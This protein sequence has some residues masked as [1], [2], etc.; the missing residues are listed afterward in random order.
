MY[1]AAVELFDAIPTGWV[2]KHFSVGLILLQRCRSQVSQNVRLKCR[3]VH[4]SGGAP[5]L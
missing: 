4:Y 2:S 1:L 3:C 5:T